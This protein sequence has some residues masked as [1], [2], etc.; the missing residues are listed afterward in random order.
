MTVVGRVG[1]TMTVVPSFAAAAHISFM[2]AMMSTAL[3]L[4]GDRRAA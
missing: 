4:L 2:R 3:R 1:M